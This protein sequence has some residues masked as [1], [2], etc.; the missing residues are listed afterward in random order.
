MR[1]VGLLSPIGFGRHG[2]IVA[3]SCTGKIVLLQGIANV[4]SMNRPDVSLIIL[5]VE[6][7]PE[8][9]MDFRRQVFSTEIII[10]KF[11]ES[12]DNYVHAVDMMRSKARRKVEAG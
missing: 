1:I 8:E 4:I 7:R 9:V 12:I 6:E 3:I 11:D 10:S 5:L 2:L